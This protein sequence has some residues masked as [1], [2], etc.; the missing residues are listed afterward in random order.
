MRI[1]AWI[2]L[3]CVLGN[4][5]TPAA[6]GK[7]PIEANQMKQVIWDLMK[8]GEWYNYIIANDSTLKN[9]KE[10]IRLYEQVFSVHGI[11]KDQ[12]YTSYKYYESHPVEFKLLLDSV[13]AVSLREKNKLYEKLPPGQAH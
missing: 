8:A 4:A 12:F 10:D 6:T 2:I 11:T 9:K 3:A 5:C 1:P 13:E 7:K